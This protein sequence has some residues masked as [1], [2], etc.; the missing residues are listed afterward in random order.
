ME[1]LIYGIG[2]AVLIFI[3]VEFVLTFFKLGGRI[4]HGAAVVAAVI[5]LLRYFL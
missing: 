1:A 2:G 5:W 4:A 3:V